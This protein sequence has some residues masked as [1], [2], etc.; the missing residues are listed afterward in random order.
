MQIYAENL[1]VREFDWLVEHRG[2]QA[3]PSAPGDEVQ[4]LDVRKRIGKEGIV[5]SA[6]AIPRG[7]EDDVFG[8]VALDPV[9]P[10]ARSLLLTCTMTSA[11]LLDRLGLDA[12]PAAPFRLLDSQ[13]QPARP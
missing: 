8:E 10:W 1:S 11:E 5:F 12:S 4:G 3:L 6:Y 7:A 2:W 9:P 13:P